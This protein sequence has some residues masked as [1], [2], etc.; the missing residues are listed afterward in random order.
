MFSEPYEIRLQK[1]GLLSKPF[2]FPGV[3]RLDFSLELVF[4]S[5][6]NTKIGSAQSENNR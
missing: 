6:Y 4:T 1:K 2:L 3:V 5:K